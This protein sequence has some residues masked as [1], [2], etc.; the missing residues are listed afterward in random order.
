MRSASNRAQ[1]QRSRRVRRLLMSSRR[2]VLFAILSA[3][4]AVNSLLYWGINR[5]E[6]R[7]MDPR[8]LDVRE[9]VISIDSWQ[10]TEEEFGGDTRWDLYIDSPRHF[11]GLSSKQRGK[12]ESKGEVK[13]SAAPRVVYI[14][15][16]TDS[17][18]SNEKERTQHRGSDNLV[19]NAAVN[20]K[21]VT[22]R[23]NYQPI[24]NT[25]QKGLSSRNSGINMAIRKHEDKMIAVRKMNEIVN[26]NTK[27]YLNQSKLYR[28]PVKL[29]NRQSKAFPQN[30]RRVNEKGSRR[31]AVQ[32]PVAPDNLEIGGIRFYNR[33]PWLS[34]N[35]ADVLRRLVDDPI[36]SFQTFHSKL[37]G[38]LGL[39]VLIYEPDYRTAG[40]NNQR[41]TVTELCADKGVTCAM[42]FPPAEIHRVLAFHLD[43]VLG[44]NR[45]LPT[46]SRK[47]SGEIRRQAGM[48]VDINFPLMLYEPSLY[49]DTELSEITRDQ[50]SD[51]LAEGN[52]G[53]YELDA[54][55][56]IL[57]DDW[58]AVAVFD[59]LLQVSFNSTFP[60]G[61]KPYQELRQ[62]RHLDAKWL[63]T[64]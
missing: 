30:P 5:A 61:A 56:G 1:P 57:T 22:D 24:E 21:L 58:G 3:F 32:S 50:L 42:L 12:G 41:T 37:T 29:K 49:E 9:K 47:L 2:F 27:L 51:C 39:G 46:V 52:G 35:D 63:L 23:S 15:R 4:I 6:G 11:R 18:P 14:T 40:F 53:K 8:S 28:A 45:T 44:F 43:R 33:P 16:S 10:Q 26:D 34:K 55:S 54:C 25:K 59:F 36:A 17:N 31:G 60:I 7:S 62:L 19:K 13:R 64:P 20:D 38:K 48:P